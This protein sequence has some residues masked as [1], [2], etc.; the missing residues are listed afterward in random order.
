MLYLRLSALIGECIAIYT[1]DPDTNAYMQYSASSEF[2]DLQTSRAG[3]DFFAD[4]ARE[5]KDSIY[6]DDL[7]FFLTEFTKEK[8]LA[9]TQKG[10]VFVL[11]YR[12]LLGGKPVSVCLRGGAVREKDSN[13][14]IF[15]VCISDS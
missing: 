1:V 9:K 7:E 8:V 11:N 4:S 15:G 5:V 13:E 6:P 14:L 2:S 10:E 3:I 12:L